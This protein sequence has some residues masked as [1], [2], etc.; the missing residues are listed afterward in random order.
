MPSKKLDP[1][2]IMEY[3]AGCRDK[4]TLV[5]LMP[6]IQHHKKALRGEVRR[7]EK[8]V[9]AAGSKCPPSLRRDLA[10]AYDKSSRFGRALEMAKINLK[11]AAVVSGMRAR[12]V[13]G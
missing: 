10:V 8:L 13:L 6:D 9:Q 5:T 2:N 7:L 12:A 3:V 1:S 11:A 4:A